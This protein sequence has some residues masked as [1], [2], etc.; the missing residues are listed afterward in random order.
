VKFPPNWKELSE[1]RSDKVKM[2]EMEQAIMKSL[3][4]PIN[5]EYKGEKFQDVLDHLRKVTGLPITADKRSLEEANVTYETPIDLKA[6]STTRTVLKKMLGGMGLAYIIKDE[7]VII[8]TQERASKET[9]TKTYYLG[10]LV[11]VVGFNLDPITS[12]LVMLERAN[13]LVSVIQAKVEPSTWKSNN[14]DAAGSITFHPATMSLI[15]NQT[16]EW[17]FMNHG[18]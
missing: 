7:T 10:D 14:P 8:M 4:T 5:V 9:V 6:R 18:K 1:K 16:A 11:G 3:A 12:Q 13:Q 15:V 17:H 2:T